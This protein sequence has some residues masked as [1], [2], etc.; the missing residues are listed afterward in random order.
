MICKSFFAL[1]S[2]IEA[3]GIVEDE[4]MERVLACIARVAALPSSYAAAQLRRTDRRS[5]ADASTLERYYCPRITLGTK[6][7]LSAQSVKLTRIGD[8]GQISNSRR[9]KA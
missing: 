9:L 3:T 6:S 5:R 2:E 1:R 7:E 4:G 8:P